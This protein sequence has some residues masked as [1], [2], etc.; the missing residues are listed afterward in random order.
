MTSKFTIICDTRE[1]I[2][3]IF[4]PDDCYEEI[5]ITK[6]ETGDYSVAGM[7]DLIAIDRKHSVSE[8][9]QN[10]IEPR[11]KDVVERMAA[12]KYKFLILEF[13]LSNVMAY[14][15]GSTVPKHMWNKIRITP[16]FILSFLSQLQIEKDIHI[17]FADDAEN[18]AQIILKLFKRIWAKHG[19]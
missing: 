6:L 9:A 19:K 12:A 7:E 13:N 16:S 8:L 17:I 10:I 2:P 15:I 4:P 14:P 18:A 1:K 3:L 11:F 5:L